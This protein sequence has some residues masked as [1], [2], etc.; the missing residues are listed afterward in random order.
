MEQWVK[1]MKKKSGLWLKHVIFILELYIK[2]I[3]SST[4]LKK[5][6]KLGRTIK[7]FY[8]YYKIKV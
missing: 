4:A 6:D 7:Y 3:S 8:I 1:I 2:T 5:N